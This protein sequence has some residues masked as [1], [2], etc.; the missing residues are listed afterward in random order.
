MNYGDI[1]T[2]SQ[3]A[4]FLQV[5]DDTLYPMLTRGDIPA[6]KIKGQWRLIRQDLIDWMRSQYSK[7]A[8]APS[9]PMEK[10]CHTEEKVQISGGSPSAEYVSLLGLTTSKRRKH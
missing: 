4:E 8:I 10:A 9:Y 6:A 3:A 1:L 5:S 2:V 7:S